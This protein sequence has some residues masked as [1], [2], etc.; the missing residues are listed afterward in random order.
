LRDRASEYEKLYIT[1]YYFDDIGQIEKELQAWDLME[2]SYPRMEPAYID[3]AV[4]LWQIGRFQKAIDSYLTAIRLS[5]ETVNS[6]VQ[7]A[8]NYRALGR[9]DEAKALL[10]QAVDRKIG[11]TSLHYQLAISALLDGDKATFDRELESSKA[12]PEGQLR[13]L[14]LQVHIAQA[15]GQMSLARKLATQCVDDAKRMDI[16]IAA[17][18]T[19]LDEGYWES[20]IGNPT[21][22]V[23]AVNSAL[24]FAQSWD[25]KLDAAQIL[26]KVGDEKKA[27]D[28]MA[29]VLKERPDDSFVQ[30]IELPVFHFT[31]DMRHK[32]PSAAIQDLSAATPYE[33]GRPYV[34]YCRGQAYLAAN[35]PADAATEFK[36]LLARRDLKEERFRYALAQLGLA[37]AYAAS[38]DGGSA[39]TAYQDFFA[40]WK[41]A[42]PEIPV[43]VE[44]RAEYAK[45]K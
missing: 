38:G 4:L 8:E 16:P 26:A 1:A 29:Q 34:Y 19:L 3:S 5:P 9:F 43:L 33:A 42:D 41:D 27:Q 37:R 18:S 32:N 23:D 40:L 45:L 6:Y 10:H 36:K 17:A 24:Q 22:A 7:G 15:S 39:R 35:R 44:A 21:K 2:Q 11:G 25:V 30:A 13:A 14:F 12:S 20:E 31:L 28:L